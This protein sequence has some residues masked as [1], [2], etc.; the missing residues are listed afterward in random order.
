M[1]INQ[2]FVMDF[3]PFFGKILRGYW[4]ILRAN[5]SPVTG[6]QKHITTDQAA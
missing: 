4:K 6:N 2:W 5:K 3:Y 1:V